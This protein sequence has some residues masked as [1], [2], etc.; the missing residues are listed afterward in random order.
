MLSRPN[1]LL[2]LTLSVVGVVH[3]NGMFGKF[4]LD[5]FALVQNALLRDLWSFDWFRLAKRPVA[6][7]TFAANFAYTGEDPLGFHI[8]NWLVHLS[9][10][11]ALF[12]LVHRTMLMPAF[13]FA[14]SKTADP[15]TAPS[16][17]P[18]DFDSQVAI[19]TAT[20][21]ATALLW[22]VHPL[23]TAA[24]TYIVQR[25][26]SFAS[27]WIL[28]C[29]WAWSHA[30]GRTVTESA[31]ATSDQAKRSN[32]KTMWAILAIVA[33]YAAYGSKEMAAG[34]SLTV[35]LYDRY[36]LADSWRGLRS[37]WHWYAV[38]TAPLIVGL[39]VFVPRLLRTRHAEGSTIG[40]GI[41]G[42]TPWSYLTSQPVVFLRYLRLSVL[43]IG[44][45]LDYG[46]IPSRS[47]TNQMIGAIAWLGLLLLVGWLF[48]RF[49][50]ASVLVIGMLVILAPTSTLLPLQDI[51]FEHR[52]YLP[53]AFLTAC[54]VGVI[55]HRL[56][57]RNADH[58][59]P[60]MQRL[61][62]QALT[63]A[64]VLAVPLGWLTTERNLDYTLAARLYAQ[65]CR[66][67]PDN[68]RAWF[69]LANSMDFDEIEPKLE[70]LRRAVELSEQR[71]F[72]YG[73]TDYLYRRELADNLLLSDRHREAGVYFQEALPHC[74]NLLETTE[75]QF[76]LALIASL[77]N[78]PDDAE[79]WFQKALQGDESLQKEIKATYQAHRERVEKMANASGESSDSPP[80][81]SPGS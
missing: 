34:L 11:A 3:L 65:D 76:R 18:A 61:A 57:I 27:L 74:H 71:D 69:S 70:M 73:G 19:A 1:V 15:K 40:F 49:R 30:F 23:T 66:V 8:V 56:A 17:S 42:F 46:W 78:R 52:F 59:A 50:R 32:N 67:N 54:I 80:R 81:S 10:V 72:F 22:G 79:M 25:F 5:D 6:T 53:L 26:E 24:V 2:V 55:V 20:A 12:A 77:D 37:R 58:D 29:L 64:L 4:V 47:P 28:V 68:P 21:T 13:T 62:V 14:S 31:A 44:Q 16:N 45:S 36:F 39:F 33:A 38:L 51:I 48:M 9:A 60:S 43:P 35:L 7:A 63:V 75:C 41:D